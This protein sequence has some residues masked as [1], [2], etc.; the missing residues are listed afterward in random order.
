MSRGNRKKRREDGGHNVWRSYSDMMSGLLLLFVLIMAVCLMQ[1]Q[2]NYT[3]KLAEQAKQIQTQNAL[4]QSQSTVAQQQEELAA[5]Q[6]QLTAQQAE[7]EANQA[8]L[9]QQELTLAEQ[10]AMLEQL[11]AALEAQQASLNQKETELEES[12]ALVA[13]QQAQLTQK[14]KDLA[15][16]QT[17]LDNANALMA[18]QQQR[19]DQIIGVKAELI[20]A[21]NEEVQRNSISVQIDSQ[22]GAILLDSS[23]LF[24][25][26]EYTL[27]D[28][29]NII[30]QQVLPVYCHVL[31]GSEYADYVGEIIIDGFTDTTGEYYDNLQLSQGRALAVAQYLLEHMYDFL[32]AAQCEVLMQ[33]LSAN[34]KSESNPIIAPDGQV[35]MDASRR[36]EIK[37]RLKDEEMISELQQ[38]IEATQEAQN[39]GAETAAQQPAA[40][41][42]QQ[43][44]ADAAQQSAAQQPTAE[45]DLQPAAEAAE[46][47]AAY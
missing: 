47:P 19:I 45:A 39:T 37:F 24:D 5:S 6:E 29:G 42:T 17:L 23:V 27:T 25:F 44:A 28:N 40:D 8:Q 16:S 3:E 21:L 15:D 4:E 41:A 46:A 18:E 9:S 2:K 35:D 14:E 7:L 31:L 34:G 38:L 1:A 33:K 36:V 12:K 22:T 30:L 10:A 43:P 20:E 11:Q 13:S 32:D 26:N